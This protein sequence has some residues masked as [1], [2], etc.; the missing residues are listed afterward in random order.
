MV[1]WSSTRKREK[2]NANTAKQPGNVHST[3]RTSVRRCYYPVLH[4]IY[5]WLRNADIGVV[6]GVNLEIPDG[7]VVALIGP[8]GAGKSST[9]FR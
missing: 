9:L 7:Q 4:S 5:H 1:V 2:F 3:G 8:S 6:K